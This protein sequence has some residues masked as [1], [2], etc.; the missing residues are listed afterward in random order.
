MY[1][2]RKKEIFVGA[3]KQNKNRLNKKIV[4]FTCKFKLLKKCYY[5]SLIEKEHTP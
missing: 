2:K 4:F 3:I 1:F 5:A